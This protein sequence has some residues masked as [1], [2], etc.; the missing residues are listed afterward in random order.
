MAVFPSLPLFIILSTIMVTGI[1]VLS[2]TIPSF[3]SKRTATHEQGQILGVTQSISSMARVPGPV[4]GGFFYEFAGVR[5]PFFLSA[6]LLLIATLL[7][8]KVARSHKSND[9]SASHQ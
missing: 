5:A 3:I 6:A 7:G 4:I 8:L 9:A 2:T 1:G